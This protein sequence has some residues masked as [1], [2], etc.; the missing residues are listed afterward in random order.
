VSA[1]AGSGRTEC[2]RTGGAEEETSPGG[3]LAHHGPEVGS[4]LVEGF[5]DLRE[6]RFV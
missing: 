6:S 3:R 5:V 2:D 4:Q 1:G